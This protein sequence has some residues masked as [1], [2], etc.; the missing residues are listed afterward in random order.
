MRTAGGQDLFSRMRY[1]TKKILLDFKRNNPTA[2][3]E[4]KER[5]VKESL[6]A[7][8]ENSFLDIIA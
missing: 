6:K 3:I 4:M 8:V 1:H 7:Q 2:S 5:Y